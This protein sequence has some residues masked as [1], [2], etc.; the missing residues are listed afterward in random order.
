MMLLP[1][2]CAPLVAACLLLTQTITRFVL[3]GEEKRCSRPA[4]GKAKFGDI[5]RIEKREKQGKH[6]K[7]CTHQLTQAL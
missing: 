3:H 1:L 7:H 5:R 4:T 2:I 6:L